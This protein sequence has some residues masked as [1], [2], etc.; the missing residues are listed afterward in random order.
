MKLLLTTTLL[1]I[2][3]LSQAANK[4]FQ[5][6][7]SSGNVLFEI[8]AERVYEFSNGMA[9][10]QQVNL[11]NNQWV[12]GKGYINTKGEVVIPCIYDKVKDFVDGRAWVQKKGSD[13]W[14][15]ID[16]QGNVIPTK[17]YEKVGYIME[18]YSDRIAVYNNGL[19]GW[20][21]R[22]G[23][24][25]IPCQY[26]G[27]STFDKEFGLACVTKAGT[28]EAYGFIDKEGKVVI[29]FQ[30]KQAGHSSFHNGYCRVTVGGKTVLI[31]EKGE[32]QFTPKYSSLQNYGHG[33]MPVAT[34]PNRNGWG[35]CNLKNEMVV[36]G[37]YDHATTFNEDGF[38]IV[39]Q[40]DNKGLI[41][42]KGEIL[43]D[44]K[45]ETI[46]AD[47]T[48]YGYIC[49]V[50]HTDEPTSLSNTPKDYFDV[51]LNPVDVGNATLMPADGSNRIP[52]TENGMRGFMNL[53]FEIVI[54]AVYKKTTGFK[55]G[56]AL[57][58]K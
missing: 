49:A 28:T 10:I 8:E 31:N 54:P 56:I 55:D 40:S 29:P 46:Y 19:M 44:L 41:N 20:I 53:D 58:Q 50:H 14:T 35:Y 32:V 34:K 11:V 23:N 27:S 36:P 4:T 25:V 37:I 52:F 9:R 13:T 2:T 43:L 18:G 12:R 22:D 17:P 33:L 7:D 26:I 48:E 39:E 42:N 15:L 24:E 1:L 45:Y 38:A 57:V 30:Y 47:A 3:F 16:K 5:A 21:D 6:I 51:N